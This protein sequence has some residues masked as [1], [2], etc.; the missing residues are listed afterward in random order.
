MLYE[1]ILFGLQ[2]IFKLQVNKSYWLNQLTNHIHGI[3]NKYLT[4]TELTPCRFVPMFTHT[5]CIKN[6]DMQDINQ[7]VVKHFY[8]GGGKVCKREEKCKSV[9]FPLYFQNQ[10]KHNDMVTSSFKTRLDKRI[11]DSEAEMYIK[12]FSCLYTCSFV[13]PTETGM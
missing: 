11:E 7:I 9:F 4:G 8:L 10:F 6:Q 5:A 13:P 2:L 12:M 1:Q 3:E